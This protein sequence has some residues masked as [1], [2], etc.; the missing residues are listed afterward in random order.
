LGI[1]FFCLWS[2]WT[3]EALLLSHIIWDFLLI[4]SW[5]LLSYMVSIF[6]KFWESSMLANLFHILISFFGFSS[7]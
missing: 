6:L 3:T 4:D 2:F 7:N 5:C 1:S